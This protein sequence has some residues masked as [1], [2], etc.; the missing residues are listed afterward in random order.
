MAT[1]NGHQ[2]DSSGN[3]LLPTAHSFAA[4]IETGTTASQ[5][6]TKGTYLIF[7]NRLCRATTAIAG[8]NTLAIGTNLSQV[9]ASQEMFSHLRASSGTEFY[10]DYQGG[11]YGFNTS[12]SKGASTFTAF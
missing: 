2:E 4:T 7:N 11:K 9:Y 8:G 5:A 3:I 6:Y 10:L 1:Y 12:A